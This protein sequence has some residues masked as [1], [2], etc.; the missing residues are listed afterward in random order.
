MSKKP[1]YTLEGWYLDLNN[2][3][4]KW[5][6]SQNHVILSDITLYARWIPNERNIQYY[7]DENTFYAFTTLYYQEAINHLSPQKEGYTFLGWYE[8]DV[9]FELTTMPDRNIRLYSKWTIMAYDLIFD[10]DDLDNITYDFGQ[11][12][13]LPLP[14]PSK[15]GLMFSGWY[16]DEALTQPFN[17][18]VMPREMC[19]YIQ[20]GQLMK[21]RLVSNQMVVHLLNRL[22]VKLEISSSPSRSSKKA[23]ILK[24]G[25]KMLD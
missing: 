7:L 11:A 6:F 2:P 4:S 19:V 12:I 21:R 16:L 23:T 5:D 24:A 10:Y 3:Q 9:L 15:E 20:N 17:L 13:T 14:T 1:G 25:M 18:V 22:L 8:D